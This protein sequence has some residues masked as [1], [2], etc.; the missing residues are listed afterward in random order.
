MKPA[1]KIFYS[2]KSQRQKQNSNLTGICYNSNSN[3]YYVTLILICYYHQFVPIYF[4]DMRYYKKL[5]CHFI[6]KSENYHAEN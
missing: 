2:R 6:N 4:K 1:I 3:Y 5:T